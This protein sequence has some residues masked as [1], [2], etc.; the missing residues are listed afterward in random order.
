MTYIIGSEKKE[1]LTKDQLL[2][3]PKV[4]AG[5]SVGTSIASIKQRNLT[6]KIGVAHFDSE[7]IEIGDCVFLSLART[8]CDLLIVLVPSDLSLREQQRTLKF[9]L[10]E[11]AFMLAS[12]SFV[13][14]IVPYDE[15]TPQ[16]ILSSVNPDIVYWGRT[17][18][19]TIGWTSLSKVEKVEIEHPFRERKISEVQF[20]GKY[21]KV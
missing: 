11:R 19:E 4:R 3:D 20:K 10:A 13:D 2:Y 18:T 7:N 17:E 8:K 6:W 16:L 1:S 14:Y 5:W 15:A 21:F 9:D 12:F